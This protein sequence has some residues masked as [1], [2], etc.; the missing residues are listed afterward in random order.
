MC[1]SGRILHHLANNIENPNNIILMVGYAA[2]HTLGRKI[3][4]G[5][6]IVKIF[7]DQYNLNAEVIVLDSFSAHAD[8]DEL[9]DYCSSIDKKKLKNVF[10]V[11]GEL[12]QQEAF[13]KNLES[14]GIKS[15]AIPQRGDVFKI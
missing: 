9:V 14:I 11:H 5:E 7:G 10:L 3:I 15:I 8:S 2:E 6:K 1:E 12:D 13:K 4:N